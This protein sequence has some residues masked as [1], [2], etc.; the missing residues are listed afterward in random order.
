[1]TYNPHNVRIWDPTPQTAPEQF[2]DADIRKEIRYL[3]STNRRYG[4]NTLRT[5]AIVKL[6]N[7]LAVRKA[8]RS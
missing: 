1:M 5:L 6:L 8:A 7:V 3:R 2:S 4:Q